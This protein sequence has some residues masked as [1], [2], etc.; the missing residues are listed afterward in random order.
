MYKKFLL[1][2]VFSFFGSL[3]FISPIFAADWTETGKITPLQSGAHDFF[4]MSVD[5]SGDYAVISAVRD[6]TYYTG[7]SSVY[8][9]HWDG[10]TWVEQSKITSITS[11]ERFGADVAIDGDYIIVGADQASYNNQSA[12]G[13]AYIFHRVGDTWIQ[14]AKIRASNASANYFFGRD[15]DISGDYVIVGANTAD[16][17]QGNKGYSYIFH[18]VGDTWVQQ[19]QFDSDGLSLSNDAYGNAV[20][21][22]G[23]YAVVGAYYDQYR[24]AIYIYHRVGDTWVYQSKVTSEDIA[25]FDSFGIEVSIYGDQILVGASGDNS[26]AGAAYLFQRSGSVW[27]QQSKF[28]ASEASSNKSFGRD[29]SLSNNVAL[30]GAYELQGTVY[31]GA[32]YVLNYENGVWVE[33]KLSSAGTKSNDSFAYHLAID[34]V[35]AIVGAFQ[36]DTMGTDAGAVY[37]YR[38]NVYVPPQSGDL[39]GNVWYDENGNGNRETSET[40]ELKNIYISLYK[41]VDNSHSLTSGDTLLATQNSGNG[42]NNGSYTF[43]N[44]PVENYLIQ[45]DI[46]DSDLNNSVIN[47][48]RVY[49]LTTSEV[50]STSVVAGQVIDNLNFGFDEAEINAYISTDSIYESG[51]PTAESTITF[52]RLPLTAFGATVNLSYSGDATPNVDYTKLDSVYLAPFVSSTSF[53]VQA[54]DDTIPE[55]SELVNVN[56]VSVSGAKNSIASPIDITIYDNDPIIFQHSISG[57]IWV[58][59]NTNGLKD[60]DDVVGLKN[61]EV[62]LYKDTN[63]LVDTVNSDVFGNY[64]FN[65]LTDGNYVIVVN[66]A[67]VALKNDLANGNKTYGLTTA[68]E[69][70]LTLNNENVGNINFGFAIAKVSMMVDKSILSEDPELGNT[71]NVTVHLSV[72]TAFETGMVFAYGGIAQSYKP[73]ATAN[74]DY[75]KLDYIT[76][77]AGSKTVSFVLKAVQDTL[78]EYPEVFDIDLAGAVNASVEG[79]QK[80]TVTI[81]DD[82]CT[83]D[84]GL[85]IYAPRLICKST[86]PSSTNGRTPASNFSNLPSRL[87]EQA[88]LPVLPVQSK[89]PLAPIKQSVIT[90][91]AQKQVCSYVRDIRTKKLN[92]ICK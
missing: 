6:S 73:V 74:L 91:P 39:K 56:V 64:S 79:I 89:A 24:G 76:I 92:Y 62:K 83:L 61:V 35:K 51:V 5:I 2:I 71:T 31:F 77:P 7:N 78:A 86:S 20:A 68:K 65:N 85:Y 54:I 19:A 33:Q 69:L 37:S 84:F 81:F 30:I 80:S 16:Y 48:N 90:K 38:Q 26:N 22:D 57:N 46:S 42:L 21:I 15:V 60:N 34:G 49:G 58:D 44:L 41:D 67:S 23:D 11:F 17:D 27:T 28:V 82:N 40:Y 50:I 29:V 55:S 36:D 45:V 1:A 87:P 13:A 4:G 43:G 12:A 52:S 72:P 9:Y 14:Q 66:N 25:Q 59:N 53:V 47:A 8:V 70:T 75:T 10:S 63:I 3:F 88:K 18:R 32:A